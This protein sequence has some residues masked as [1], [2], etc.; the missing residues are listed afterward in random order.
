MRFSSLVSV[1][2]EREGGGEED[3]EEAREKPKRKKGAS[4]LVG[5]RL[6]GGERR[7]E[8]LRRTTSASQI[9]REPS[10]KIG[11]FAAKRKLLCIPFLALL[12]YQRCGF[13]VCFTSLPNWDL[14]RGGK[15]DEIAGKMGGSSAR[16]SKRHIFRRQIFRVALATSAQPFSQTRKKGQSAAATQSRSNHDAIGTISSTASGGNQ[17]EKSSR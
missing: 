17:T 4:W 8:L 9:E 13:H 10:G 7:K 1:R 16:F 12:K 5:Q 2:L 11:F 14:N 3:E 6:E 15:S